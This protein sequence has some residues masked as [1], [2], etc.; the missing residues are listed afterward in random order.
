MSNCKSGDLAFIIRA[1]VTPEILGHI[2]EVVGF[3]KGETYGGTGELVWEVKYPDGRDILSS[4]LIGGPCGHVRKSFQK[5]RAIADIC[6]RPIRPSEKEDEMLILTG[7]P[8]EYNT[9]DCYEDSCLG[10]DN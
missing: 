6:L 2:V 3:Y 1:M 4:Q 8:V 9:C 5:S 7:L 10:E